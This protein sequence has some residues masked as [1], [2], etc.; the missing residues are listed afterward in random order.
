MN[1]QEFNSLP[2]AQRKAAQ[3]R[4]IDAGLYSG[5]ADGKWG[6][7]TENAF[8]A[9]EKRRIEDEE[10]ARQGKIKERES[11]ALSKVKEAEAEERKA[12]AE[13][14]KTEAQTEK[15]KAE[16]REKAAKEYQEQESSTLGIGTKILAGPGA[17]VGGK[18]IGLGLGAGINEYMNEG[19]RNKNTTLQAAAQDRVKGL[20]T[21]EGAVTGAKLSGAM[22]LRSPALRAGARMVPHLGLGALSLG[23]GAELLSDVDP[24]QPFYPR[25]ADRGFGL[26][27]IGM[28]T[29]LLT[30]GIKHAAAP[31]VS[32]DTQA[33]S[34]INSNQLRR[35]GMGAPTVENAAS[36]PRGPMK[37][38]DAEVIPEPTTK[39]LPPPQDK[40]ASEAKRGHADRL[41]AAAKGAGATGIKSKTDAATWLQSNITEE[42]RAAIGKEL[43]VKPGPKFQSRILTAVKNMSKRPGASSVIGPLV[44]GLTAYSATPNRAQA[45]T[46]EDVPDT[47]GEA[48]TNAGVAGGIAAGV[49]KAL[50]ALPAGA[51]KILG[52]L[53]AANF[54][55]MEG[56]TLEDTLHNI[57]EARGDINAR[58]PWI[59]RNFLDVKPEEQAAYE[60]AQVPEPGPRRLERAADDRQ[61]A[62]Y[63]RRY[64]DD[65]PVNMPGSAAGDWGDRAVNNAL[66]VVRRA[67][68]GRVS[69]GLHFD[70]GGRTDNIPLD[71]VPGTYI[72][73][74]DVVSALGQGNTMAG[75]KVLDNMFPPPMEAPAAQGAQQKAKGGRVPIIAAGGEF[76][77]DPYHVAQL[78][79]GD[80]EQG[81]DILDA[82]VQDVR[83][84]HIDTL[85]Q[86]PGPAQ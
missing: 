21:R 41:K 9:E 8:K 43:G 51:S 53:A 7:G 73:P 1:E 77:V 82:F 25:M 65:E 5:S 15:A 80:V 75:I 18:A 12:S 24:E 10:R 31:K 54:D 46:G 6:R 49:G 76:Q 57:R 34:V 22:P 11:E 23:T 35:S 83:Q 58:L 38:I 3:Q 44:A 64:L 69:G 40:T 55:P 47:S 27:N 74:A 50:K 81:A 28:G 4:L 60:K 32:P 17:L 37:T 42:N 19:Q 56:E 85:S 78:G 67:R 63:L 84:Q 68:G 16:R 79:G 33:L 70:S 45:S 86:L 20:T 14:T 2:L 39:A 59:G 29:G 72:F 26:G 62:E 48:L 30:Q 13:K 36:I 71:V 61:T 52:P 66:G